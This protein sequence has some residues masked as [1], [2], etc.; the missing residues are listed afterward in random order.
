MAW[1]LSEAERRDWVRAHGFLPLALD[2]T[3]RRFVSPDGLHIVGLQDV[4]ELVAAEEGE[5]S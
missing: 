4:P 3:A 2:P 5:A 1:P